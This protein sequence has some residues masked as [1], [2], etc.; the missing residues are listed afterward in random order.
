MIRT[1]RAVVACSFLLVMLLGCH[2]SAQRRFDHHILSETFDVRTQAQIDVPLDEVMQGCPARDCIPSIDKPVFR[3]ASEP[4]LT[5]D[6]DLVIGVKIG[7]QARAYPIFILNQHEVVNDRIDN[8]AF[9]VTWCPLCGS[10]L[11]FDRNIGSG[12]TELG[13]SGLLVNSDLVLY[14]R[15]SNSLWQQITG[16][17]IAGPRRG[18]QLRSLPMSLSSWAQWRGAHPGTQLLSE[19]TGFERDYSNKSPYGDYDR[20]DRLLFPVMGAAGLR[21]HPKT[22]VYAALVG[23][24]P[25]AIS[26]RALLAEARVQMEFDGAALTW[27][28]LADG[29]VRARVD[30]DPIG[31]VHRVFW[32]AWI[33]F[34]PGTILYDP[35]GKPGQPD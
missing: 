34:H 21:L 14:D 1:R 12:E 9:A 15:A 28:R 26:E 25:V 2:A 10:G 5:S 29:R 24:R 35:A 27:T 17:A 3:S 18:Q 13:V 22:V 30:G 4:G 7:E 33:S 19:Q 6:E 31:A 23:D 8:V 11:V 20:S 32:F 16:A